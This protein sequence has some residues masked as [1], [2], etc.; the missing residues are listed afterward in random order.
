[1]KITIDTDVLREER[2]SLG[3]FLVLLMG[4]HDIDYRDSL[5]GLIGK[6]I[7][8]PNLFNR[9]D[10]VLSD[11]TKDKVAMILTKSDEKVRSCGIDF[12]RLAAKLQSIYPAHKKEGTSYDWRG[13]TYEVAQKLRTLVACYDFKFTEEEAANATKE[14]VESFN[15]NWK[16]MQLLKYFILRTD[17]K[18]ENISS[19]FMSI[20]E[21]N[22]E[23]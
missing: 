16:Q 1:M 11:N 23:A 8:Q 6:D 5:E 12:D 19:Q 14:Y 21:N 2:L 10:V 20:I 4:Y 3:E 7:V 22:R 17:G 15:G 18:G 9:M 13:K